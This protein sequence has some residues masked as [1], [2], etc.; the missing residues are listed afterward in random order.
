MGLSYEEG[1]KK[2]YQG[3]F[4]LGG[5]T[6][7][8]VIISLLGKGHIISG[9]DDISWLVWITGL[10]MIILSFY[11][12]YF[13][14][15]EFMHMRYEVKGLAMTVLLP[16]LLLVWGII[17]FLWE[18]SSWGNRRADSDLGKVEKV[19]AAATHSDDDMKRMDEGKDESHEG[20]HSADH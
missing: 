12:A 20:D 4:L 7:A 13:I 17:A 16:T 9:V 5:V 18:G 3:L 19:Q 10:A 1:I 11:K 14:I 15:Y 6:L 2:V 8:E